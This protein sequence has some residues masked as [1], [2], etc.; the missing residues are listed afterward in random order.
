MTKKELKEIIM[1]M[2]TPQNERSVNY[3]LGAVDVIPEDRIKGKHITPKKIEEKIQM[4]N[5]KY[6]QKNPQINE[7]F[8]YS[9]ENDSVY[10][11]YPH[12]LH[13]LISKY[14]RYKTIIE[15]YTWLIDAIEGIIDMKFFHTEVTK[16]K[17]YTDLKYLKMVSPLLMKPQLRYLE[18]LNFNTHF[19]TKKQLRNNEVTLES[20][21][22]RKAIEIFQNNYNIG[23]AII[24]FETMKTEQWKENLKCLKKEL[25]AQVEKIKSETPD[26]I[27]I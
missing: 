18:R 14:G 4:L 1:S 7:F 27:V 20:E 9:I 15:V 24:D 16:D 8:H 12:D 6:R 25:F 3:L 26:A 21:D 23:V 17:K 11:H 22:V 13:L 10:L 5:N 19:Y 2:R